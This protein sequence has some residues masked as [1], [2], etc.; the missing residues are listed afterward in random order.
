L[1]EAYDLPNITPST[2]REHN[3]LFKSFDDKSFVAPASAETSKLRLI[4][5][6]SDGLKES[7][8]KHSKLVLMGQDIAKYGG[9]FKVTEGFLEEFGADRVWNR[10]RLEY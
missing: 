6:V 3:D 8:R 5:A 2:E 4:D 1:K 10:P 9:V 7:M